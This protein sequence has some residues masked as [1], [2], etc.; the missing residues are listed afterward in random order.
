MRRILGAIGRR[1]S[2]SS[3]RRF[4]RFRPLA[5]AL[6]AAFTCGVFYLA[7]W[8]PVYAIALSAGA[9]SMSAQETGVLAIAGA[10]EASLYEA[11]GEGLIRVLPAG[12]VL[13]AVGRSADN[14]WVLV[15]T[16]DDIAGWAE[17]AQVVMFGID[18]LPVMLGTGLPAT[19]SS[20]AAASPAA[21]VAL[22]TPTPT[23]PPT[24]TPTPSPTPTMTPTPLPTSTPAPV[25]LT[26]TSAGSVMRSSQ[27]SQ[28]AVVR[29]GGA[30]LFA[31]P[32]GDALGQL[33]T[34]T[35]LTVWGRSEDSRWL[36]AMTAAGDGGWVDAAKV[37]AFNLSALP[38]VPVENTASTA[39]AAVQPEQAQVPTAVVSASVSGEEPVHGQTPAESVT[40]AP[41]S[42]PDPVGGG[43][44]RGILATVAITD[45]RLNVRSGPD[46]TYRIVIKALPGRNSNSY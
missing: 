10:G 25:A 24:A 45:S 38:V 13:T 36:V 34:G 9:Q 43:A 18:Q 37:V 15:V 5:F 4:A 6:L 41:L 14:A 12:A 8:N 21:P 17:T 22:P 20:A 3:T 33:A 42:T 27:A 7:G 28:V 11:P 19:A 29:A 30:E 35:A 32:G 26:E 44:P 39:I 1:D 2:R 16:T 23:R 40:A 46:V 31:V